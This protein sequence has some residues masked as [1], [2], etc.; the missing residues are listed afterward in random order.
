MASLAALL[1]AQTFLDY[2]LAKCDINKK[3][4]IHPVCKNVV[5][6]EGNEQKEGKHLIGWMNVVRYSVK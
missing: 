6:W 2:P 4:M 1:G 3:E 5:L